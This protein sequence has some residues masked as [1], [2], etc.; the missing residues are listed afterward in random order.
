MKTQLTLV[1]HS[2]VKRLVCLCL[3]PLESKILLIFKLEKNVSCIASCYIIL[4]LHILGSV[5]LPPWAE[6]PVDFVHKH[7]MALESE[8]VS[9][10]LHEWIDL[11]FGYFLLFYSP[12]NLPHTSY[13][14]IYEWNF[15][16]LIPTIFTYSGTSN[17]E[18]KLYRQI[19]S[20][21]ILRTKEL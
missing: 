7:R 10:H 12:L 15:L 21:F 16:K 14:H 17:V 19:M 2:L 11:V 9:Q 8:H 20:S 18:K 1:Q 6:N 5:R 4:S 3:L 13:S